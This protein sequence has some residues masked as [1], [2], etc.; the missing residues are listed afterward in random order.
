MVIF[1]YLPCKAQGRMELFLIFNGLFCKGIPV[2]AKDSKH[3]Q[4]L[5]LGSGCAGHTAAVY[6][7]R[8]NLNPLVLEGHEPGGQLS[9][10]SLV[11]NFP[12]FPEGVG[13]FDL[14]DNMKKQA[15]RFGAAY[16]MDTATAVDLGNS[17]FRI[18]TEMNAIITAQA[19]IIATGAR[20]RM[21]GAPGE[22]QYFVHGVH[23]C[24]T[25]DAAFYRNKKV[26][27]IG[28]GDSALEDALFLTR[29]A[30]EVHVIHRRSQLRASKIMQKRTMEHP[31][32][33]LQWNTEVL[34]MYGDGKKLKGCKLL[35]HPEGNPQDKVKKAGSVERAGVT[36]TD[37]P[38]DGIFLALGHIPNTEFLKGQLPTNAEGYILA[39]RSPDD[40]ASCDV[41]TKIPGVFVAG[42]VADYEYQQAIT[43]A[44]MGCKAA[45]AAEEFLAAQVG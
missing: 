9:L 40:C 15:Q 44:G 39:Q 38:C 20:A 12:G 35:S 19:I 36:V 24:A 21:S 45:I 5:I 41:Y 43:A 23:T 11:E 1:N 13:G 25:C 32:I 3:V 34:E 10:T 33:K 7:A 8:A 31:K 18:T 16:E 6:A 2:D 17:P 28:G 30:S 14:L 42:D 37:F 26:A 22:R 4:L 29:F 27:V